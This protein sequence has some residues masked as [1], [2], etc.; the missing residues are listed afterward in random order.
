M[1][2]LRFAAVVVW[3]LVAAGAVAWVPPSLQRSTVVP[4]PAQAPP[5]STSR[6]DALGAGLGAL[7]LGVAPSAVL[8]EEFEDPAQCMK[9]CF[10]ECTTLAPGKANEEYC[11]SNCE[12]Y[13]KAEGA[14]GTADVRRGE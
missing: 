10:K 11:R 13:C 9:S 6:R 14:K 12:D 5:P 3:A 2:M 4:A 7:L 8:A 1:P